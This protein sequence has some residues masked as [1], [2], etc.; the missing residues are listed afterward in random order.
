MFQQF[1]DEGGLRADVCEGGPF[2]FP[3]GFVGCLYLEEYWK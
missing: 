2:L 1:C 3:V